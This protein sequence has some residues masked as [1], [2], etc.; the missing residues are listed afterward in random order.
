MSIGARPRAAAAEARQVVPAEPSPVAVVEALQAAVEQGRISPKLG[1][2][3]LI[4]LVPP[5]KA[6]VSLALP[7]ITDAGSYAAACRVVMAAAGEGRIAPADA[8]QLLRAAKATFEAV[9]LFEADPTLVV[10]CRRSVPRHRSLG[11]DSFRGK[12]HAS[13]SDPRG[14]G[15]PRT[16]RWP[17]GRPQ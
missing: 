16:A 2:E 15:M 13:A 12:N 4:R 3:M 6:T 14:M 1:R 17:P 7:P 11:T 10:R 8:T 9:R 5:K